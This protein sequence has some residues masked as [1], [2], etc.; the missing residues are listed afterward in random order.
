MSSVSVAA[1][2]LG[3]SSGRVMVGDVGPGRLD[4]RAVARFANEPV[5]LQ[6]GLHWD[7]LELYRHALDGLW[8]AVS[9]SPDGL[10]SVAVDSWA[11]DYALLR[12]DRML[13]V[14]FHYRDGRT[15][16]GVERIHA[17]VS[18]AELYARNGLQFLPFNTIYQ[19]AA[20]EIGDADRLLLV[21]DLIGFWLTGRMVTETT[22]ASTTGLLD[23]RT[24]AW[25]LDLVAQAGLPASILTDLVGPGDTIGTVSAHVG[26]RIGAPHLAV[27]AVG[28]HDTASAVVGV[29]MQTD[30]AAYISCGTWGLVGVEL[31]A[32]VVT[33]E[34]RAA[35]FT[36]EGGVDGRTRFLTNVMGT[37]LISETLRQWERDGD[38]VDLVEILRVAA[39]V[40]GPVT[41]FDVQDPRFMAPGDMPARVR[42]WCAEHGAAAPADR[43]MLMRSIVE[44]IA[45]AFADAL[46]AAE[47]LSGRT[48]RV[49]HVVGG[50]S[51]NRLL[52]QATADR[53]GRPVLAGPVE[54]TALGNVLVQARSLGAVGGTLEEMRALIAATHELA[55]FSPR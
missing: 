34:A 44:S 53:S 7:P 10:G 14:P 23:P 36:N 52:C 33:E 15:A 27:T 20:D 42:E 5:L 24:G 2:D 45:Q 30:D 39:D 13:G 43:A 3:A 46:E 16:R 54:A 48:I 19:L 12:G 37:W 26:E 17:R 21:P 1:I 6:D 32:P 9:Q 51:Q 49:V 40:S 41:V 50:G 47:R 18:P 25:D 31:D 4:L 22:N 8:T 35:N 38:A 11:V 29:P 28:S 55:S